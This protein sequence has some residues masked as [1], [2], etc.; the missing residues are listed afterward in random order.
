MAAA[1]RT[2]RAP[3]HVV[4][5]GG[6]AVMKV[7][8]AFTR[9]WKSQL[10][11]APYLGSVD[12]RVHFPRRCSVSADDIITSSLKGGRADSPAEDLL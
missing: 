5:D 9:E 11:A 10:P 4:S 2:R 8:S 6:H 3:L 1:G 12:F 7:P